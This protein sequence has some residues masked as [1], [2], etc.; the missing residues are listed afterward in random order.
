[1]DG[2]DF[3][4]RISP[5]VADFRPSELCPSIEYGNKEKIEELAR[6]IEIEKQKK[7]ERNRIITDGSKY[8]FIMDDGYLKEVK[9]DS[10]YYDDDWDTWTCYDA[11]TVEEAKKFRKYETAENFLDKR[12]DDYSGLERIDGITENAI[13]VSSNQLIN[14]EV[15]TK[16]DISAL[17]GKRKDNIK[18]TEDDADIEDN[19][20][21]TLVAEDGK[22]FSYTTEYQDPESREDYTEMPIWDQAVEYSNQKGFKKLRADEGDR[23]FIW[24]K[25]EDGEFEYNDD[26]SI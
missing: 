8:Y 16:T 2:G 4:V 10:K 12:I 9:L 11:Q 25:N 3:T 22:E 7:E 17:F 24:T 1:M 14:G 20:T 23:T 18:D 15:K 13:V 5:C 19:I 26:E 21:Y 6:A